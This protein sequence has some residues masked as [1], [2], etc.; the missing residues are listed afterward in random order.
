MVAAKDE[1]TGRKKRTQIWPRY[2]QLDVRRL[3]ADAAAHGVGRCYL[4]QHLAGSGKSNSIA[5]LAHQLIGLVKK[6]RP[7]NVPRVI[8]LHLVREEALAV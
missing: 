6:H 1:K 3:L 5:W 2:H 7:A 4:I 8:R